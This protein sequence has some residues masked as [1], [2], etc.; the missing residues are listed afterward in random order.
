MSVQS[1]QKLA[2][3]GQLA[4]TLAALLK[5][6]PDG[7]LRQQTL[8]V[9][10]RLQNL[11]RDKRLGVVNHE[12]ATLER[13]KISKALLDII[14]ELDEKPTSIFPYWRLVAAAASV[15]LLV[16]FLKKMLQT[17]GEPFDLTVYV[18]G[19]GTQRP[20]ILRGQGSV[21]I[22]HAVETTEPIDKDGAAKF[23]NI[24]L[25]YRYDSVWLNIVNEAGVPYEAAHPTQGYIIGDRHSLD[26][27]IQPRDLQQLE[28]TIVDAADEQPLE[29]ARIVFLNLETV[30]DRNGYFKLSI[31][32]EKQTR[33]MSLTILKDG[34][35]P[36]TTTAQPETKA[37]LQV[38]LNKLSRKKGH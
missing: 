25:K 22:R 19:E 14:A 33:D 1:L 34:Y 21:K 4:E 12:E 26:L 9:S 28:G 36:H 15:L 35:E 27:V 3:K 5:Q 2:S 20:T 29:N 16:F 32:K 18:V 13:N 11:E 31:P 30:T 8:A 23:N 38:G 6:L 17:A 10:Q 7:D 24:P 37:L